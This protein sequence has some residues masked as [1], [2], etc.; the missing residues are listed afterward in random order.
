M[1]KFVVF[2]LIW[3]LTEKKNEEIKRKGKK[4]KFLTAKN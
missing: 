3:K 2:I 4:K 1:P